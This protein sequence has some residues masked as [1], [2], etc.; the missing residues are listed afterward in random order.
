LVY[1][2]HDPTEVAIQEMIDASQ[3]MIREGNNRIVNEHLELEIKR[4]LQNAPRDVDKLEVLLK[5]KERQK[6]EVIHIEDT[7]RLVTEIE[8]FRV[9]L[10]LVRRSKKSLLSKKRRG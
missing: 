7:Q 1:L 9:V 2:I 3:R 8:M 4:L 5:V 6:A 10:H